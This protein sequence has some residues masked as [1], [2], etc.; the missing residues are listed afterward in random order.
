MPT[1]TAICVEPAEF[2]WY[3]YH[4]FTFSLGLQLDGHLINSGHSASAFDPVK[5]KPDVAG[6]MADQ[7]HVAYAKQ[8]AVLAAAG[9][10]MTDVTRVVENVTIEGL[11][12]Y[13][14]AEQVR[15]E[16]FGAHQPVVITVIVD[17]LV[18]RKALIEVEVHASPGAGVALL[19]GSDGRWRRS[20]L[21]EGHDGE[22]YLPTL[23]PLDETGAVVSP[24]NLNGQ[25]AYCVARAG[26]LLGAAGLSA[27]HIVSTVEYTTPQSGGGTDPGQGLFGPVPPAR[28]WIVMGRLHEPGVLLSLDVVA[29]RHLPQAVVPD[30]ARDQPLVG[31]PAVRAGSTL[32]LSGPAPVVRDD[33]SA[34]PAVRLRDQAEQAYGTILQTLAAVGAQPQHL[35]STV[36][37][38]TPDSLPAYRVVAEVRR[39]LLREPYPVSTGIVCT[40]NANPAGMIEVVSTAL[41]PGGS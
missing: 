24:G 30:W 17:R 20:T 26:E 41:I 6:G 28:T 38:V 23:L 11:A 4:G 14:E 40:G 19:S 37:Y 2:P 12:H 13:D 5:G 10:S 27:A 8:A 32:Y 9:L 36:E 15:R 39:E 18:R 3:D 29:S 35:L 1:K 21:R 7:A 31:S 25:Y 22:V 34:E 33:G 16:I